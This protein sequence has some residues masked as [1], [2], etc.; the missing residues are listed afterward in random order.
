MSIKYSLF[1]DTQ[2]LRYLSLFSI[3]I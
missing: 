1:I 2:Q 3:S